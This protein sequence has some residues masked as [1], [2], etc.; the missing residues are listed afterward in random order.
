[1]AREPSPRTIAISLERCGS[2]AWSL[3]EMT[4]HLRM[5]LQAAV[6]WMLT[7]ESLRRLGASL[8]DA[9]AS[10]MATAKPSSI[11]RNAS[12]PRSTSSRVRAYAG[13]SSSIC[14][15]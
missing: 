10:E 9:A 4:I 12:K 2:C 1:M 3:D 5:S 7:G 15:M 8:Q 14:L 11:T 13:S 6:A